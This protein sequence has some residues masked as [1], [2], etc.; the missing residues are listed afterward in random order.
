MR[1]AALERSASDTGSEGDNVHARHRS[2]SKSKSKGVKRKHTKLSAGRRRL[3]A[4]RKCTVLKV[5]SDSDS[6]DDERPVDAAQPSTSSGVISRR[7]SRYVANAIEKDDKRLN[8]SSNS[9]D[10]S[11]NSSS[12]S[13]SSSEDN[14][15][16]AKRKH[17]KTDSDASTKVQRRKHRKC[18]NSARH[19]Y[20]SGK[21]QSKRQKLDDESEEGERTTTNSKNR[22]NGNAGK[23]S[24]RR[25]DGPSTP[26]NKSLPCTPDSGIKSG[27]STTGGKNNE[28]PRNEGNDGGADDTSSDHEQK[29]KSLECFRKKVEELT[30][31]SYR[32]RSASQQLQ[33]VASSTSDSSD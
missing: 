22:V 15:L 33:A 11:S 5:N 32:N 6:D 1:M 20:C 9:S 23:E 12:S 4:R 30:R 28:Q 25:E 18:K 16:G 3:S 21:S 13:S 17:S 7:S 24:V 8:Y 29:L 19:E 10:S 14:A 26:N 31:R 27:I 2:K